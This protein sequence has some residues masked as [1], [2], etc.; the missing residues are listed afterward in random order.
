[1]PALPSRP[2][3]PAPLAESASEDE[4]L[5]SASDDDEADGDDDGDDAGGVPAPE[6][7]PHDVVHGFQ[8]KTHR[9]AKKAG[10]VKRARVPGVAAPAF[11]AVGPMVAGQEDDDAAFQLALAM[12]M[13]DAPG[14]GVSGAPEQLHQLLEQQARLEAQAAAA[15]LKQEEERAAAAA[16]E[17]AEAD[18]AAAARAR[19]AVAAERVRERLAGR[20]ATTVAAPTESCLWV[21]GGW[22]GAIGES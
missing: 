8:A 5:G 15:R 20:W 7:E 12:S 22:V 16:R 14:A 6:L 9:S 21:V 11:G 2:A 10:L 13:Q 1:M 18:R 4:S 19:A 3:Q 17:A